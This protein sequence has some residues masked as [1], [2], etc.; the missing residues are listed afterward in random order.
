M[1]Y[2]A[3]HRSSQAERNLQSSCQ[4]GHMAASG[5]I[6]IENSKQ[7]GSSQLWPAKSLMHQLR[8]VQTITALHEILLAG[9]KSATLYFGNDYK[10]PS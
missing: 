9:E 6:S 7:Y 2:P 4:I 8:V 5:K 10:N 1:F 3:I